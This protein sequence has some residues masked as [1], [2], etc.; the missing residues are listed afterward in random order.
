M[1]LRRSASTRQRRRGL[2]LL[3]VLSLLMLFA[4]VG[5]SFVIYAGSCERSECAHLEAVAERGADADP[6]LLFSYFMGHLLY[7]AADDQSGVY[8][9]LRG[10]SLARSMYGYD[11]TRIND[12]PFNGTGRQHPDTPFAAGLPA[13]NPAK[14][15]YNLINY[16]YFA[17]DGFLRDPERPG[18]RAGPADQRKA[19]VGGF[20]APYTYPDLNNMFL[21]AVKTDGTVMLPS[22]HRPW[23]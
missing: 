9:G 1:L 2:I 4:M 15:D 12:T 23:S 20:N 18:W 13:G 22:F 19:F 5:V 14:D 6:E 8:S 16:T 17:R 3:V 7:D 21:A 11:D 10:H